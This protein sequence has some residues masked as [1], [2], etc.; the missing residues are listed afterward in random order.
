MP[1]RCIRAGGLQ[2]LILSVPVRLPT[3]TT[4]ILAGQAMTLSRQRVVPRAGEGHQIST[5]KLWPRLKPVHLALE[6]VPLHIILGGEGRA[7]P[8]PELRLLPHVRR[9]HLLR[10]A[11]DSLGTGESPPQSTPLL[12]MRPPPMSMPR[13]LF[14]LLIHRIPAYGLGEDHLQ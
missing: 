14:P 9:T 11:P 8:G 4:C 2:Q 6:F 3:L 13:I 10:R 12:Q 1:P 7:V 5:R